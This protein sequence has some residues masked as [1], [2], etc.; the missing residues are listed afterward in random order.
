M[1]KDDNIFKFTGPLDKRW[2][3]INLALTEVLEG[4]GLP[5]EV[6]RSLHK[7]AKEIY[8]QYGKKLVIPISIQIPNAVS[9]EDQDKIR[10]S[11]M[12]SIDPSVQKCNNLLYDMFLVMIR[13][14][15]ECEKLKA[16]KR[17]NSFLYD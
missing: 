5:A 4:Q 1:N 13:T 11:I 7:W 9:L 16:E 10:E 17:L 3:T 2:E 8:D 12:K 6:S 14:K 15:I